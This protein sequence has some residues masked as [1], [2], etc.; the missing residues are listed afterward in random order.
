MYANI[1]KLVN[2]ERL[3]KKATLLTLLLLYVCDFCVPFSINISSSM[4]RHN[5]LPA[6]PYFLI[7]QPCCETAEFRSTVCMST[8]SESGFFSELVS[9]LLLHMN[10]Q[11]T[12]LESSSEI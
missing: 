9:F 5:F 3:P 7:L 6:A 2:K 8:F 1:Y 4:Q 12:K 10:E 11:S